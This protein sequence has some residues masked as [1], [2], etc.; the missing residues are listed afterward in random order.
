LYIIGREMR[1]REGKDVK[2]WGGMGRGR[3]GKGEGERE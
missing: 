1:R 3:E 2:K